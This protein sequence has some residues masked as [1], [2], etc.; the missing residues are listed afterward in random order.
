MAKH[1]PGQDTRFWK[2]EDIFERDCPRCKAK[3]EFWK[4]DVSRRCPGCKQKIANPTFDLG[5]AK[6]CQYAKECLGDAAKQINNEG[7]GLKI[8][9][10]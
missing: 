2:P 5:C 10:E 9:V 1:C 8:P 3:I 4:D 6:W 7:A